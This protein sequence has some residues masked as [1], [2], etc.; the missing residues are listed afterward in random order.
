MV[1]KGTLHVEVL[2]AGG[3]DDVDG[4]GGDDVDA[5]GGGS[6]GDDVDESYHTEEAYLHKY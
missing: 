4:G 2:L 1:V 3:I 6:G 5:G